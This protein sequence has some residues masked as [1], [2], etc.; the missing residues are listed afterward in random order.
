MLDLLII[1]IILL[2]LT[3]LVLVYTINFLIAKSKQSKVIKNIII[4]GILVFAGMNGAYLVL[5]ASYKNGIDTQQFLDY[6]NII[7]KVFSVSQLFYF[8][9]LVSEIGNKPKE[10]K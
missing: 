1:R 4:F 6:R 10:D 7:T 2:I 9:L 3:L 8:C 5:D